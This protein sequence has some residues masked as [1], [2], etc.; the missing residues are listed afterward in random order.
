MS[1]HVAV[2]SGGISLE[3]EVSL[4][5][6][7][8][9]AN[10]LQDAGLRVTRLDLDAALVDRLTEDRPDVVFLA[11]HGAAGEDGTVQSVLG[12]LELPYT[13]PDVLASS[14]AWN[15]PIA[16]GLYA[17]AGLAVPPS[18]TLSRQAVRELG[19]ATMLGR[20]SAELGTDLVVKPATGGSSLGISFV[21]DPSEL[22]RA[23]LGAFSYADAVL[24]EQRIEGTEVAVSVLDGRPLPAVEIEAPDGV[25]DFAARYT[26]GATTFH[27]PARLSD[28]ELAA[29]AETAVG[30]YDAVGARHVSRADLI[31][32]RAGT[33]WILEVDTCP[34]LTETSLLP[35]AAQA[36]GHDVT[37]LC[38]T[39]VD[40]ALERS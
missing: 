32:D 18:V 37:W 28:D 19:A 12:L 27:V 13:G 6:G 24:V 11:V 23:V 30:A 14:L 33:P 9:V 16:Q 35:L 38:R 22:P 34:G 21:S 2:I 20:V 31:V 15:K 10:A 26:A 1:L 7:H 8:R 3:R 39:L 40:L 36:E 29:C 4:R 17:R 5:S 25:Y